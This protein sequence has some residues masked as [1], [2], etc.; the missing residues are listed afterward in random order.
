M[1]QASA[2]AE[3]LYEM[4]AVMKGHNEKHEGPKSDLDVMKSQL[5]DLKFALARHRED[6]GEMED[7]LEKPHEEKIKFAEG[8]PHGGDL[9]ARAARA[10]D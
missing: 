2:S 7:T 10:R 4:H 6:R 1:A 3:R 8:E 5:A 9:G